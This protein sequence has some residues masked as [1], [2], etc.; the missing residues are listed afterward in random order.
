MVN[1]PYALCFPSTRCSDSLDSR[2][3]SNIGQFISVD[4]RPVSSTRGTFKQI[5]SLYRSYLGSGTLV[6]SSDKPKDPVLC[7]HISCPR[8]SYDVNVEPAKDDVLFNNE[9]FVIGMLD[10]LFKDI[11][12]DIQTKVL[13]SAALPASNI[14][15]RGFEVLLA[16]KREP[17]ASAPNKNFP[18]LDSTSGDGAHH[19]SRSPVTVLKQTLA[20]P[21]GDSGPNSGDN[22][23]LSG[24]KAVNS[25]SN[26]SHAENRHVGGSNADV[27]IVEEHSPANQRQIQQPNVYVDAADELSSHTFAN[28]RTDRVRDLDGEEGLRDP[29]VSNP[30]TFAKINT[31]IRQHDAH[32]RVNHQLLT[33]GYQTGELDEMIGRQVHGVKKSMKPNNYGLPTPQHTHTCRRVPATIHSSSPEPYP[34]LSNNCGR[35]LRNTS[36]S[37][38][39]P[40]ETTSHDF[41][42]LDSWIQRPSDDDRTISHSIGFGGFD[43]QNHGV[44]PFDPR[45]FVSARTVLMESTRGGFPQVDENLSLRSSPSE[46][47][48]RE[49]ST[50]QLNLS[51]NDL[52]D[53]RVGTVTL[54]N[55]TQYSLGARRGHSSAVVAASGSPENQDNECTS[56]SNLLT[57]N[58]FVHPDLA[59]ALDY[60][61]RKQAAVKQ[62]RAN[63]SSKLIGINSS[64]TP[65]SS[66]SSPHQNRYRRALATLCQSVD[67]DTDTNPT[68]ALEY[69]DP[70]AYL[71]RT[72][73]KDK[74]DVFV[75][76]ARKRRKTSSLP[77]ET[78]QEQ[79]TV[80]DLTYIFDTTD[81]NIDIGV[82]KCGSSG[83]LLDAY[84]TSGTVISGLSSEGLSIDLVQTWEKRVKELLKVSYKRD[85]NITY[86]VGKIESRINI[87]PL[88]QTH[89]AIHA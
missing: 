79:N 61:V 76:G 12:G 14:N 6:D 45:D 21:E 3:I 31:P 42:T 69:N 83:E 81:I 30:W 20:A 80:R 47:L 27:T 43:Q 68:S 67:D 86:E 4:S 58:S 23:L 26:R 35:S 85:E 15:P 70:R 64:Q 78:V 41:G 2:V 51:G 44:L 5:I 49:E 7:M 40:S 1:Y 25:R 62:W 16:K 73:E 37:T 36:P 29:R 34:Y 19:S 57:I 84:I 77:L 22:A 52:C 63:Q 60:E 10:N 32:R 38:H 66:V 74:S 46:G 65:N 72:Q 59:K 39:F 56:Q 71:I 28:R 17:L 75:S 82:G 48:A 88:M 50:M 13:K 87:W 55:L 8:A 33:P 9:N 54:R 18:C 89:L 53:D 11:Y 24:V